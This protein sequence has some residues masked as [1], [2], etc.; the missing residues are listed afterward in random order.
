MKAILTALL[1]LFVLAPAAAPAE[2]V[3]SFKNAKGGRVVLSDVQG[4]CP[5]GLHLAYNERVDPTDPQSYGCWMMYGPAILIEW[6]NTGLIH[7]RIA[8]FTPAPRYRKE[9]TQGIKDGGKSIFTAAIRP[10]PK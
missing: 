1:L 5:L 2:T 4:R 7:Y 3:A 9:W 6:W 10:R 8:T